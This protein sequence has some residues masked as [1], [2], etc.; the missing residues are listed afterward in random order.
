[1][2]KHFK[3]KIFLFISIFASLHLYAQM[4]VTTGFTADELAAE[5][6]GGG[7][8]I[9]DVV[10]DCADAAAGKFD[11]VDCNVGMESGIVLTSGSAVVTEGPNNSGGAGEC[12]G[13]PGDD[14]LED[15]IDDITNDACILE[16]DVVAT[17]DSISFDYVFG[18]DEYLEYV[19]SFNDGFAFFI[20]GPGIVGTQNIALVPGT[21]DPVSIDNV[22]NVVNEEYYVDNGD[23]WSA[24]YSTDD[25]YIQYDGF[26]TVLTAKSAVVPCETYH[27]KLVVADALDCILDSGVFIKAGSLSSP[28]VTINYDYDIAGYP[29]L[30]EGCNNGYLDLELSFPPLDT[31]TV[32][33][34]ISGTATNGTDYELIPPAAIFYPGDTSVIIPINVNTDGITEGIETIVITGELTCTVTSGDSIVI[35][36]NDWVPLDAWPDTLICPGESVNLQALGANV[37]IWDNYETL[38]QYVGESVI[39]T[40]EHT[41]DYVVTGIFYGCINTDTVTVEVEE[42]SADAGLDQIILQGASTELEGSGGEIYSW[43]PTETLSDPN[44]ANPIAQPLESTEYILT[45]TTELGCVYKDSV[46]IAVYA[47]NAVQLPNVFS[48]NGDGYNDIFRIITLDPVTLIDFSI[49]NRWGKL[50]FETQDI[51]TGWDG[52][53]E[54]KEQEV[55]TYMY[56]FDGLDEFQKPIQFTG[57]VILMR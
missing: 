27:L 48:P 13:T 42:P 55:G 5:L 17:S 50:I 7:V 43:E 29:T 51:T 38:D 57:N 31:I 37:Y 45:V 15:F 46:I 18:S 28:G 41:T 36:I 52:T 24:P 40:P 8:T 4:D 1:M 47:E 16:F 14:D 6:V 33:L 34:D 53:F 3:H 39:A 22:N 11:C 49:F 44:I 19:F 21:S 26:T 54:N 23:G 10:L 20:S 30:I 56:V 9:S 32:N 2:N 35:E 12:P 25:Y